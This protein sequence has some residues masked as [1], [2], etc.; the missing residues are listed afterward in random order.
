MKA[1]AIEWTV[2]CAGHKMELLV[3]KVQDLLYEENINEAKRYMDLFKE[4]ALKAD[5]LLVSHPHHRAENGLS[6]L[7]MLEQL[8]KKKNI[9]R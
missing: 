8:L 4:L 6:L 3:N 2:L 5:R 7:G 9:L 1:D